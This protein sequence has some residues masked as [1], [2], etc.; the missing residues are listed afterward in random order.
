MVAICYGQCMRLGLA[1]GCIIEYYTSCHS[2]HQIHPEDA[3]TEAATPVVRLCPQVAV[4]SIKLTRRSIS[5][6]LKCR[7]LLLWPRHETWPCSWIHHL[8][9]HQWMLYPQPQHVSNTPRKRKKW[10]TFWLNY[11]LVVSSQTKKCLLCW[12]TYMNVM[13]I[14][15][16]SSTAR[17]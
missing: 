2:V 10:Q 15:Y 16:V 13:E 6:N 1:V 9:R 14:I 5:F 3:N 7:W 12:I 17:K 11:A 8:G 4:S